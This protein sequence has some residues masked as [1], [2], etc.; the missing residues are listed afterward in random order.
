MPR[1]PSPEV[2]SLPLLL[3][4]L[5]VNPRVLALA[6]VAAL[7]A[8]SGCGRGG[9]APDL[10]RGKELFIGE[11]Q[12]GSCH[13]L[14]RA[15]TAGRAG[16]NLDAAFGPSVRDGLGRDTVEGVV[17]H[18]ILF[19]GEESP[20]P[21]DLVTGADARDVA[22]YVAAVAGRPG[23][24]EGALAT[25]GVA[26]A[27]GG[28]Q[29]FTA[30]GCGSCHVLSA[31]GTQGTIGPSLDELPEMAKSAVPSLSPEEYVEQSIVEPDEFVVDGFS[32]GTM[33]GSYGEQLSPEQVKELSRYLLSAS[34][35]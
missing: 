24:D 33:P 17:Q 8:L 20:M 30:A 1:H 2:A 12:C 26:G 23:D 32:A 16:P 7:V 15:G 3:L 31:A 27:T 34:G 14:E 10:V 11:G 25:A 5:D 22:A 4:G 6:A 28:E 21:A 29:I 19:P 13:V 9:E 18:Q 35:G